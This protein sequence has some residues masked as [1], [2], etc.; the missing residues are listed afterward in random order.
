MADLITSKHDRFPVELSP[1]Q[2]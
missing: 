2:K 1:F